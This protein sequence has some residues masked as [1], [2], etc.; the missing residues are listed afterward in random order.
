MLPSGLV[1]GSPPKHVLKLCTVHLKRIGVRS[2]HERRTFLCPL[3]EHAGE[4]KKYSTSEIL[5]DSKRLYS[6]PTVP[7]VSNCVELEADSVFLYRHDPPLPTVVLFRIQVL[8]SNYN[9][10]QS[11]YS[12]LTHGRRYGPK[13]RTRAYDTRTIYTFP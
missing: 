10:T 8:L 4:E 9:K 2:K 13:E 7:S 6:T 3:A 12:L 5:R 11:A 1:H